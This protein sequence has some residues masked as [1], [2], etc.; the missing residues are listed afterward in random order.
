MKQH[1]VGT[2]KPLKEM[3]HTATTW[4]EN[5]S[6]LIDAIN[7]SPVPDGDCG[8]NMLLTMRQAIESG[9]GVA[10]LTGLSE[11]DIPYVMRRIPT[12]VNPVA[13]Y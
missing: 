6:M 9:N 2:G 13:S 11:P 10:H 4:L 7:V 8:K 3:F 12:L 1:M 5:N